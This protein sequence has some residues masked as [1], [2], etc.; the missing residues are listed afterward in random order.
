ML[1]LISYILC[2]AYMTIVVAQPRPWLFIIFIILFYI[3]LGYPA[4]PGMI[5]NRS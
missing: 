2:Y 5:Q 3:S 1:R 4:L